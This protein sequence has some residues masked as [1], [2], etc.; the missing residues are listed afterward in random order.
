VII[1]GFAA[2]IIN[3]IMHIVY[4]ILYFTKRSHL[5]PRRLALINFIFLAWQLFYF[6]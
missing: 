4:L 6:S 3:L 2:I 1:L 5:I